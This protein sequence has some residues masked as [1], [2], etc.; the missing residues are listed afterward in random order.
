MRRIHRA[1]DKEP[2]IV[3]LVNENDKIFGEIWRLLVF[4]AVV[5]QRDGTREPLEKTDSGKGIDAHIFEKSP[6]WPGLLYM[7]GLA[8]GGRDDV[9]RPEQEEALLTAFEEY[10]NRGLT[11][12]H[13]ALEPHSY[14]LNALQN[15]VAS[16]ASVP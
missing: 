6:L 16:Q 13:Q 11:L 5:G 7:I 12:L 4:A 10:A 2:I 9:F 15:F 1:T 14:S 8:D 3:A